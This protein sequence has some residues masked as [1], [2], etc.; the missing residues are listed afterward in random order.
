MTHLHFPRTALTPTL[1]GPAR[2]SVGPPP[3][4]H[5]SSSHDGRLTTPARGMRRGSDRP[6]EGVRGLSFLPHGNPW[7]LAGSAPSGKP[8]ACLSPG[9]F[10]GVS[11]DGPQACLG[12]VPPAPAPSP[13]QPGSPSL[14]QSRGAGR[15]CR[16]GGFWLRLFSLWCVSLWPGPLD[17][18]VK[19]GCGRGRAGAS[20]GPRSAP[21]DL[22]PQL[23]PGQV[24]RVDVELW[25]RLACA[26]VLSLPRGSGW[27]WGLLPSSRRASLATGDAD[28]AG[29]CLLSAPNAGELGGRVRS[30]RARCHGSRDIVSSRTSGTRS[31]GSHGPMGVLLSAGGGLGDVS[32]WDPGFSAQR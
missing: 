16:Q 9:C 10:H 8:C 2:G 12:A 27:A 14:A 13:P 28:G 5:F 11:P 25:P 17:S 21:T 3:P 7:A 23:E 4:S 26:P 22:R 32:S 20:C 29:R 30:R 31:Q 6:P 1:R 24:L 18:A 19:G 15:A